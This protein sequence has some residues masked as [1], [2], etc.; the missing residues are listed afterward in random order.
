MS[1]G[2]VIDDDTCFAAHAR[3]GVT[4]ERQECRYWM[5]NPGTQ[6]CAVIASNSGSMTLEQ[7]GEIFGLTRMRVCQIEKKIYKKMITQLADHQR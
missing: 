7:V 3:Y 1:D 4:C 2:E 6:N 5:L